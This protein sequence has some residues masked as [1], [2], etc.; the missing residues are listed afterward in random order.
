MEQSTAQHS[1]VVM[2]L[3]K[4][5]STEA[6]VYRVDEQG[7]LIFSKDFN[8]NLEPDLEGTG[9]NLCVFIVC[10]DYYLDNWKRRC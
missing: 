10:H 5:N 2:I 7:K 3:F 1:R 4:Q 8:V 6:K 9:R